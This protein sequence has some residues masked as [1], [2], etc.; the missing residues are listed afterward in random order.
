MTDTLGGMQV[1]SMTPAGAPRR[2]MEGLRFGLAAAGLWA[3]QYVVF[4]VIGQVLG[5]AP[6]LFMPATG[7]G[8]SLGALGLIV[9]AFVAGR[10]ASSAG[11]VGIG[12]VVVAGNAWW[13]V[14]FLLSQPVG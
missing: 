9:L 10:R 14:R 3:A 5:D 6:S 8:N 11:L 1:R 13:V 12:V 2:W 7:V 4:F